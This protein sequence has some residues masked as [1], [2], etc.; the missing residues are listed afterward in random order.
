MCTK[1]AAH[2][3]ITG[4]GMVM[5]LNQLRMLPP[6]N[7]LL[8]D[9]T[10]FVPLGAT[11]TPDAAAAMAAQLVAASTLPRWMEADKGAIAKALVQQLS[12]AESDGLASPRPALM[13]TVLHILDHN[14]RSPTAS[15]GKTAAELLL[16]A[17][18]D[19]LEK[20]R[21]ES[22][23]D[24]NKAARHLT[25]LVRKLLFALA[26]GDSTPL[27]EVLEKP[28]SSKAV[29]RFLQ[30]LCE[31]V[32]ATAAGTAVLQLLPPYG[33]FSRLCFDAEGGIVEHWNAEHHE[34]GSV[35]RRRLQFFADTYR[36]DC[37]TQLQHERVFP[38]LLRPISTAVLKSLAANGIGL[39]EP[40]QAKTAA[41]CAAD[42]YKIPELRKLLHDCANSDSL[43][44]HID[45]LRRHDRG[46][47]SSIG[48]HF[49]RWVR[50]VDSHKGNVLPAAARLQNMGLPVPVVRDAVG[51]AV[52]VLKREGH[53]RIAFGA[54]SV[55]VLKKLLE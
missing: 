10:R 6:S 21:S 55:P 32:P 11:P 34:L 2:V 47:D 24:F 18:A 17:T 15:G 8:M 33:A 26:G 4:S 42:V 1:H 25:P 53:P 5:L 7:Y 45:K 19:A 28:G 22:D 35:L 39:G 54:D 37:R 12:P 52:E 36:D 29:M 30:Q 23:E 14:A 43:P 44:T 49:L 9:H 41:S 46:Y 16:D 20:L 51:A 3:A 48:F 13:T 31:P 40:L 50:N 38:Q 27:R